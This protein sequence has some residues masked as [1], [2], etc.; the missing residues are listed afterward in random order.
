MIK[1]LM[2]SEEGPSAGASRVFVECARSVDGKS[3]MGMVIAVDRYHI[4]LYAGA[5]IAQRLAEAI[6]WSLASRNGEAVLVLTE[7][8]GKDVLTRIEEIHNITEK[9]ILRFCPECA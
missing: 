5:N 2:L 8:R 6:G 9:V 4:R 7:P 3:G 1:I